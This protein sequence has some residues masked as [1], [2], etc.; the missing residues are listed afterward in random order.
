MGFYSNVVF[1][2]GM[3]LLMSGETFQRQRQVVLQSA[4]GE[5]LEIGFGSGLNLPHYPNDVKKLVSVD[6]NEGMTRYTEKQIAQ[7]NIEVD[8]QVLSGE[9]L[10]MPDNSFDTVVSTW[11]L[12][13]IVDIEKALAEV[14]RVLKPG[15]HF[16]FLEHGLSPDKNVSRWQHRLNAIQKVIGDGCHLNRDMRQL[17]G[18]TGFSKLD[19][20]NYYFP[21]APRFLG[22]MYRGI[23][24]K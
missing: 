22:Y 15:G 20:E 10:P 3:N 8:R 9:S 17:I 11:T 2:C 12:C 23:A 5:I 6:P 14:R 18:D 24:T 4:S 19:V 16:I 13:S 21:K 1:P 7:S